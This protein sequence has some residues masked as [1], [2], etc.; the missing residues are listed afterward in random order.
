MSSGI[1]YTITEDVL[2]SL[3]GVVPSSMVTCSLAG[4]PNNTPISQVFYV[5][6]NHVAISHQFFKKTLQ[7]IQENPVMC[8][9]ITCP[10]EYKLRKLMLRFK[11]TQESGEI[12]ESMKL[13]LDI[14]ATRQGKE[15]VFVLK[16]AEI[17]E[18]LSIETLE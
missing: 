2:P 10:I 5:D 7:N 1:Q 18:I 17:F 4:I 6:E 9:I 8:I 14:I 16:A 13:Q 3:Q 15:G 12:F 11:E